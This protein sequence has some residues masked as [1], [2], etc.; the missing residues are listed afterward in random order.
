MAFN[1]KGF[2]G[3][4]LLTLPQNLILSSGQGLVV[5]LRALQVEFDCH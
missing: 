2:Y 3:V 1:S 4:S 5:T